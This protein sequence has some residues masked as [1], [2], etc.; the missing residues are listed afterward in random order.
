MNQILLICGSLRRESYNLQLLRQLKQYLPSDLNVD[1]FESDSLNLPLFNEDL[2]SQ[3]QFQ[4]MAALLHARILNAQGFIIASPEY[5]GHI[6]A[7]LKNLIDWVSRLPYL[8]EKFN[9]PFL[10]KPILLCCAST[11]HTG[12]ALGIASARDVLAYVGG[13]VLGGSI[14][15]SD[16]ASKWNGTHFNLSDQAQAMVA[17]HLHRFVQALAVRA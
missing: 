14:S 2:E 3:P 17:F 1:E 8:D 10:D 12:G 5:N 16:A 11:G 15:I 7:Y 9:N 6:T 4:E 13:L